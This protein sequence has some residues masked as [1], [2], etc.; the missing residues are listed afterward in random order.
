MNLLVTGGAGFIGS[1]YVRLARRRR[2]ER[3]GRQPRRPDLRRQPRQPR[4]AGGRPALPVRARR[5][6]RPRRVLDV[7]CGATRRRRR[8]LRRREPRRPRIIDRDAV[9][10]APTS[11]GTQCLLDAARAAGVRRFVQVSTDEVYGTLG[12]TGAVHRDDAAGPEQPYAASKAGADLLVRRSPHVRDG[13]GHHALLEQL[14]PVP[15]PREADPAVHHQRSRRP[16]AAGLRRRPAGPRLDPRRRP[17]RGVDAVLA[18]GA[19]GEVYNFGGRERAPTWTSCARSCALTGQRRV[20]DPPRHRP[21]RPRPPLRHRRAKVRDGWAGGRGGPSRRAWPRPSRGTGQPRV[22]GLGAPGRL[23][24]PLPSPA[25]RLFPYPRSRSSSSLRTNARSASCHDDSV[26]SPIARSARLSR[27]ARTRRGALSGSSAYG[28]GL[29]ALGAA[30]P[31]GSPPA[32]RSR[33]RSSRP[34]RCSGRGRGASSWPARPRRRRPRAPRWATPRRSRSARMVSPARSRRTIVEGK[35]R[36]PCPYRQPTRRMKC[37]GFAA[38]T[39]RSPATFD[40]RVSPLRRRR[41]ALVVGPRRACRRRRS[42]SSSA[43]RPRRRPPPPRRRSRR[44]VAFTAWARSGSLSARSTS[45]YAAALNT[46]V[47]RVRASRLR[48]AARVGDVAF[49]ARRPRPRPASRR[50]RAPA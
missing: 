13:R 47:G 17:L 6:R 27:T 32:G 7:A 4:D 33:P 15:V 49:G 9:R 29:H 14:R 23:C 2:P 12:P 30:R 34:G 42:R 43:R 1:T 19:P 36:P 21:P 39:S 20:A 31:P 22:G 18:A 10:A 38:A 8:Q 3:S 28:D 44:A 45:V 16:A 5:H 46:A 37:R 50:A 11:L 41:I 40:S 25:A 26:S 48:T 35:L 24:R